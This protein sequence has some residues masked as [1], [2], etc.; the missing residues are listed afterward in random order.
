[1]ENFGIEEKKKIVLDEILDDN[2]LSKNLF[3]FLLFFG[4]IGFL[5]AGVS[6]Y[7]N[8]NILFFI[9]ADSIIFFPQ[10]LVMFFYGFFGLLFS[11]NQIL[12]NYYRI[13]EGYNLFN[14]INGEMIIYRIR[15]PLAGFN[16]YLVYSIIDIVRNK[17]FLIS[18]YSFII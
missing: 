13:G 17:Y 5:I 4:S 18:F 9:R 14:K 3:D 7:L 1:M 15:Y 6:S 10:G 11:I 16:I 8:F 2:K 12:V